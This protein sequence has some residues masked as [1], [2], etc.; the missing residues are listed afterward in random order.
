M[1]YV[2]KAVHV[3]TKRTVAI[4]TMNGHGHFDAKQMQRFRNEGQASARLSHPGVVQIFDIDEENNEPFIS[5]EYVTGGTLASRLKHGPKPTPRQAAEIM[6]EV[7]SALAATHDKHI[8]HRDIKPSNILLTDAGKPK[9]TDFGL[10]AFVDATTRMTRTGAML[11]TAAYM[12]PE[13]ASGRAK[14]VG[15]LSDVY[16]AGATLY[17]MLTETAVRER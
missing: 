4:K 17:E 2:Y 16:G 7:A 14:A 8:V 6:A 1:G 5:M 11:G 12:S 9:L 13:Q 3:P 15:P 10:A